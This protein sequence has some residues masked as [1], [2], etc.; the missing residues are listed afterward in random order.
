MPSQ[1]IS[2]IKRNQNVSLDDLKRFQDAKIDFNETDRRGNTALTLA[3]ERGMKDLVL[4]LLQL[5]SILIQGKAIELADKNNHREIA[6]I[7]HDKVVKLA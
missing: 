7:I 6:E 2:A 3:A 5:P 4:N 1:L